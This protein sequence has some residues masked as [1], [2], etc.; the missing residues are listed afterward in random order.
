MLVY[1]QLYPLLDD[2]IC[3]ESN[4]CFLNWKNTMRSVVMVLIVLR[5]VD[6]VMKKNLA[7]QNPGVVVKTTLTNFF[8]CRFPDLERICSRQASLTILSES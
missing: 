6:L 8:T 1:F 3:R 7:A 5:I 2:Y 4:Y